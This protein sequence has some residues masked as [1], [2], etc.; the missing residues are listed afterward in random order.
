MELTDNEKKLII[1]AFINGYE[2]GHND[3]VESNYTDAED[4]A[5]DWL[6]DAIED[7]SLDYTIEQV[8]E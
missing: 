3:T 5:K 1:A 4:R 2:C 7:G 8:G 6:E